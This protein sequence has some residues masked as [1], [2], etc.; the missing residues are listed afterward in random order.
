MGG[1][2]SNKRERAV[3]GCEFLASQIAIIEG[4]KQADSPL[5]II[6]RVLEPVE[7]I[8]GSVFVFFLIF[9][10]HFGWAVEKPRLPHA[11]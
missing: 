4:T 3:A 9:L 1:N 2:R 5:L 7:Q 8:Q 10:V 6:Q 11:S